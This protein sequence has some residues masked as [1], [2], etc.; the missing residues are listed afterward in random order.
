MV[1]SDQTL[2]EILIFDQKDKERN[3]RHRGREEVKLG[4]RH[5]LPNDTQKNSIYTNNIL[6]CTLSRAVYKLTS[7]RTA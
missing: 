5:I 2:F 4:H 1:G 3:L 7:S 6:A